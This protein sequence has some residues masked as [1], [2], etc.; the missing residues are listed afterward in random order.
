MS[1]TMLSRRVHVAVL[2]VLEAELFNGHP[3]REWLCAGRRLR[4]TVA[5]LPLADPRE[6]VHRILV[7]PIH[8][9][10]VSCP[11]VGPAIEIQEKSKNFRG[12][13]DGY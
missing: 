13:P 8:E 11:K 9:V 4:Q 2:V 5:H 6:L 7:R 1:L 10:P 12:L 3:C